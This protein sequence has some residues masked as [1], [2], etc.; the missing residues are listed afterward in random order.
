MV[1]IL[2]KI[3]KFEY[4]MRPRLNKLY[5]YYIGKQNILNA[6]KPEGKPNN[7]I[8]ANYAKY[9]VN[10]TTGYYLG[11]PVAYSSQDDKLSENITHICEYNDDAF[12]NTQLGKD[13]SVFGYGAELLYIDNDGEIRYGKINPMNLYIGYSNDIE[14][15][16]EY[17]IRWYDVLD[18]DRNFTRY[19]EYYDDN[20]IRYYVS[21]GNGLTETGRKE[22]LFGQVPVNIYQ[23]NDDC[24]SDYEDAIPLFDAYNVMQSESV[25]DFQKFADAILAIKNTVMDDDTAAQMRDKNILELMD[26]GEASWLVKQVNDAYVENIKNRLDKDIFMTTSTVNISDENF[27]Q[28]ASGVA[29]KY[30]LMAM[31]NRISCTERYFKKALQRRF[32]MICSVLN[33]KGN[34]FKYTDIKITFDRNIP[35]NIQEDATTIQQLNGLVSKKTL[36]SQLPFIDDVE[37]EL[38]QIQNEGEYIFDGADKVNDARGIL[39]KPNR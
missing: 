28:N 29:I 12:H 8:V 31:E 34:N 26:D 14:R 20:E 37:E 6:R 4:G 9:I 30:K 33:F 1:E 24:L 10:T 3:S 5:E 39:E 25:N 2:K 7:R 38:E 18:D 16:I 32:E 15:R 23:N 13:I 36:L 17:A 21:D 22:H 19:I 27:A 11:I 35:V